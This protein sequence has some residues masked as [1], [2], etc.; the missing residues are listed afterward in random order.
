MARPLV[1]G[2]LPLASRVRG[3]EFFLSGASGVDSEGGMPYGLGVGVLQ[4]DYGGVATEEGNVGHLEEGRGDEQSF[5]RIP[6]GVVV[7][8]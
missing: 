5:V 4:T 2:F 6:E 7:F 8:V 3:E 1:V